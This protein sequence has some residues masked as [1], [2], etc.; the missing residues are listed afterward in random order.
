MN[1]CSPW[2]ALFISGTATEG[3]DLKS[4]LDWCVYQGQHSQHGPAKAETYASGTVLNSGVV[5]AIVI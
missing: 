1:L 5:E 4:L 2:P 3:L